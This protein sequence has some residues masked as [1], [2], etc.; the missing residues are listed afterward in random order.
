MQ[1]A[2]FE[3]I[4]YITGL[5]VYKKQIGEFV[6][7]EKLQEFLDNPEQ[8][9]YDHLVSLGKNFI[10][11]HNLF[12][13]LDTD[14]AHI[15]NHYANPVPKVLYTT[16]PIDFLFKQPTVAIIGTRRIPINLYNRIYLTFL[17]LFKILKHLGFSLVTGDAHG[18]DSLVT[19]AAK[20]FD[21]PVVTVK[22]T[23]DLSKP[24]SQSSKI[25]LSEYPAVHSQYLRYALLLRNRVIS[26]LGDFTICALAPYRS[27]SRYGLVHTFMANKPNYVFLFSDTPNFNNLGNHL[28]A[29]AKIARKY[30]VA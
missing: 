4:A 24:Q 18:V 8:N 25:I 1:H 13:Y 16:H 12:T 2:D 23:L 14:F 6:L 21:I 28:H 20:L 15:K 7:P 19:N 9:Q 11:R 5:H 27:G 10:L 17:R 22:P 29:L 26:F 30:H 3:T